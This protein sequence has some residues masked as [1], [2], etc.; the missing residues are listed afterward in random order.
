MPNDSW[1]FGYC[2]LY[3]FA[4]AVGVYRFYVTNQPSVVWWFTAVQL[5]QNF[6]KCLLFT[7]FYS[8]HNHRC[9]AFI[10]V[11]CLLWLFIVFFFC[12][13]CVC[14]L[15]LMAPE[16]FT[17]RVKEETIR[18]IDDV[19]QTFLMICNEFRFIVSLYKNKWNL[20]IFFGREH[21]ESLFVHYVKMVKS[22]WL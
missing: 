19:I 1:F 16:M 12:V 5:D 21:N 14:H 3:L 11:F 13:Y 6:I 22:K 20:I 15:E 2:I 4:I 18:K 9:A 8:F 10:C 17:P 7:L